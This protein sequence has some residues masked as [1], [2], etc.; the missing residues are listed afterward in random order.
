MN[1]TIYDIAKDCN[2]SVATISRVLN[3]SSAVNEKTRQKILDSIKK[4]KYAP[5]LF[6][7]GLN[8]IGTNVI[9]VLISDIGNPFFSAIIKSIDSVFQKF[10]YKIMLCS[11]ENNTET[12]RKELELLLQKRVK[13][14]L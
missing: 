1:Y 2:V 12:E 13:E 4:H 3:N 11:T 14:K 8:K 7:R 6:A 5:N 10:Q 9:G